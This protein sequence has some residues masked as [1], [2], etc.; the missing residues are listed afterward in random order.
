MTVDFGCRKML[1]C[2]AVS[3]LRRKD[4]ETY[5]GLKA[6]LREK[7]KGYKTQFRST[8]SKYYGLNAGGVTDNFKDIYFEELF[9][10]QLNENAPPYADLLTRLHKILRRNGT[11]GL[12]SS[13]VSKLIA[14]HEESWPIFD[15]HVSNFFG[16]SVPTLGS[17]EMRI[18]I[19]VG[20]MRYLRAVYNQMAMDSEI[21]N[22]LNQLIAKHSELGECHASRQIDFLV[23]TIGRYKLW[24]GND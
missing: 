20:H 21:A 5:L 8:F 13:F 7:P 11:Y 2:D 16:L 23:W 10:Y 22:I 24:K 9:S 6:L 17:L 4:V 15:K 19:F 14:I 3:Y 12:P 1:L 18:D